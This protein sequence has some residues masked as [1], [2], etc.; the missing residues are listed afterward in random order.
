M[1]FC[2]GTSARSLSPTSSSD[3]GLPTTHQEWFCHTLTEVVRLP[4]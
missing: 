1:P 3:P 2:L 4:T